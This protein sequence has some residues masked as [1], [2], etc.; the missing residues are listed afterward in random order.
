MSEVFDLLG[1]PIPEGHGRRGRPVHLATAENRNKVM[2]LLALGW[3]NERIARALG[4]T[5]PTLRKNYFR[6]LKARED[7]RDR[8]NGSLFMRCWEAVQK[9]SV[10]AIKE[11]QRMLERNDVM[12]GVPVFQ[13]EKPKTEPKLGKKEAQ[14][15]A[16]QTPDV[17]SPLG[18]LMALRMT[19][20]STRN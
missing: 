17:G 8:M 10:S 5:A 2:L 3:S 1:D 16:A 11:F 4:I 7:A 12:H 13:A 19:G 9:N 15:L 6:E 18:E 14:R 20:S